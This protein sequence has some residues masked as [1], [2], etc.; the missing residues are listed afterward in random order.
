MLLLQGVRRGRTYHT[1][2]TL[3]DANVYII[4]GNDLTISDVLCRIDP[5]MMKGSQRCALL[6]IGK[7]PSIGKTSTGIPPRIGKNWQALEISEAGFQFPIELRI[8]PTY[9]LMSSASSN[10]QGG[11]SSGLRK[12]VAS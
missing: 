8:H 1:K 11:Y 7:T 4:L 6:P 12:R 3:Q 2:I 9:S 10:I 5:A